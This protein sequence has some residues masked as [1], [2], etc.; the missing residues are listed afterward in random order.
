MSQ[1]ASQQ[2]D[3]VESI[4]EG[5]LDN[6]PWQIFLQML[7]RTLKCQV[8]GILFRS[9]FVDNAKLSLFDT[10]EGYD[11]FSPRFF[12][13]FQ[14]DSTIFHTSNLQSNVTLFS[15][16]LTKETV[17][18]NEF[19]SGFMKPY[20][21]IDGLEIYIKEPGGLEMWIE[22]GR[23]RGNALFGEGEKDSCRQ[24]VPHLCR[25][26]T[27]YSALKNTETKS[28]I[29]AE[30]VE[31]LSIGIITF[32]RDGKV[33][34][35]NDMA[36]HLLS[37]AEDIELIGGKLQLSLAADQEAFTASF[38]KVLS[39][40]NQKTLSPSIEVLR[41]KQ[42]SG[43]DL[44]LL[45]RYAASTPWY[46]GRGCPAVVVYL[47]DPSTQRDTRETFVSKL[48]GLTMSEASLA[49]ALA[50][51]LT[52]SDAAKYLAITEN[53][54]RTVSKRIFAKT[55]AKRQAELVRLILSSVAILG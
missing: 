45:I 2:Q 26:L 33:V 46:E 17:K 43:H 27:I 55:G 22:L 18:N 28:K 40:N 1:P 21:I 12:E 53:S 6:P 30:V 3:L 39:S 13:Q 48:F 54:A 35:A 29:N 19:Y 47:C 14:L 34:D 41:I 42:R 7:R 4:Y 9:P 44:G 5:I 52:L 50:E 36:N 49:I 32:D 20:N 37:L 24:L 11:H 23:S 15:E 25:A 10:D 16:M 51:G 8:S 38:H 31:Q